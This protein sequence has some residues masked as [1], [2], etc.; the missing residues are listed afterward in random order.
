[1]TSEVHAVLNKNHICIVN[2]PPNMTKF[3]QPLDLTVNGHAKRFF[4]NKFNTWYGNQISKQL[5]E[6]V[7]IDAVDVK[8]RLSTLKPLHAQWV[9]DFY[10]EMTSSKGKSIIEGGWRA[11]GITDAIRL[12]SKNLPPIDPFH[13]IDPLL[14]DDNAVESQQLEA[15]CMMTLEEKQIGYSPIIDDGNSDDSDWEISIRRL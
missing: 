9:V 15:V 8:L 3:Y 13:D 4:K 12:G 5:D 1:M 2:V 6:G 7:E 11:A 14:V 10:N